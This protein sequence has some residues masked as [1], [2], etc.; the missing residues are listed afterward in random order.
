MNKDEEKEEIKNIPIDELTREN[1]VIKK[2]NQVLCNPDGPLDSME[3]Y[4]FACYLRELIEIGVATDADKNLRSID[5]FDERQHI[6]TEIMKTKTKF[7]PKHLFQGHSYTPDFNIMWEPKYKDVVFSL[8]NSGMHLSKHRPP[9]ISSSQ[10]YHSSVIEIKGG[11]IQQDKRRELSLNLKWVFDKWAMYVQTVK[12]PDIFKT[13]FTPQ[14]Y[15]EDMIYYRP[16][17]KKGVKPGDSKIKFKVKTSAEWFDEIKDL[18]PREA[19]KSLK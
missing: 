13:T 12:V 9:F 17:S 3:E 18:N 10:A 19:Y 4:Y 2:G 11:F 1:C 8:L 15:I 5:L 7:S 16:N 6:S 14:E